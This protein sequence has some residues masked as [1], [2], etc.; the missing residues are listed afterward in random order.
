MVSV[1]GCKKDRDGVE[2]YR[3]LS[4]HC[5]P[6]TF[7]TAG[8][9][10]EAITELGATKAGTVDELLSTMREMKKALGHV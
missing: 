9:L 7:N 4:K 8:A 10:M 6:Y 2:A 3:L 1:A 5:D